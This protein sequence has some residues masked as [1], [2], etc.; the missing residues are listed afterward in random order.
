MNAVL[1]PAALELVYILLS[2]I[3]Y[4]NSFK[5]LTNIVQY[6]K[7]NWPIL[8]PTNEFWIFFS[9]LMFSLVIHIL[10]IFRTGDF[11]IEKLESEM[12]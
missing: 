10:N 1:S 9:G 5:E 3:E 8:S 2:N 4:E 12:E 6:S 7:S 11:Y